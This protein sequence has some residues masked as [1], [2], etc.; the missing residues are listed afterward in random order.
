MRPVVSWDA[1]CTYCGHI[2]FIHEAER[3]A[4][5]V[6]AVARPVFTTRI[7]ER[8]ARVGVVLY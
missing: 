8:S 4:P 3:L 6:R 2:H 1:R 5:W 7:S